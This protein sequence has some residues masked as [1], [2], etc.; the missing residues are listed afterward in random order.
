MK[1]TFAKRL[2]SLFLGCL[3][4]VTPIT[5]TKINNY[6]IVSEAATGRAMV[7]TTSLNVRSDAGTAF[8]ALGKLSIGSYVNVVG[9]KRG[10]DGNTWYQITYSTGQGDVSGYVLSSYIKFP[11]TGAADSNFESYLA[12]Q[13]FPESYKPYL[14]DLHNSHPNWKFTALQTG[15][16]WNTAVKEESVVG[17]NLTGR[18]NISSWKSTAPGAYNWDTSTWPGFDGSA[19]VAA[20]E[21]IIRYYMDPRNFINEKYIFQFMNQKYDPQ[22]QTREALAAMVSGTFLAG[23][24][25]GTASAVQATSQTSQSSQQTTSQLPVSPAGTASSG[26][27]EVQAAPGTGSSSPA[28]PGGDALPVSPVDAAS[29]NDGTIVVSPLGPVASVSTNKV[30]RVMEPGPAGPG[31]SAPVSVADSSSNA[32]TVTGGTTYVDVIMNAAAQSGVNPYILASMIIQEQG[33]Q[34]TGNSISGKFSG[35]QGYYNFFNVEAYQ[36]GSMGAVERGLWWAAQS[37]S[38]GRPW[39]TR[40]KAI[41]GGAMFYGENYLKKGQTTLYLKKFNVQ[42]SNLYKHQYMTNVLAAAAE[43]LT[44]AKITSLGNAALDFVIPVYKNMPDNPDVKPTGDGCPNNKLK[45]IAVEGFGITPSFDKDIN[46]YDLIVDASVTSV[47]VSAGALN[48]TASI[49][50]TGTI[51]LASGIN[52]IVIAVRAQNGDVRN[53]TLNIVRQTGGPVYN[54]SIS[55]FAPAGNS[56]YTNSSSAGNSGDPATG[57]G[58]STNVS[59]S[60]QGNAS[61]PGPVSPVDSVPQ[62]A[63]A[64][65]DNESVAGFGSA[66]EGNIQITVNKPGTVPNDVVSNIVENP[67]TNNKAEAPVTDNKVEA[68]IVNNVIE[69]KV[70]KPAAGNAAGGISVV[71]GDSN[72]DGKLNI[73]DVLC[74]Q[75]HILGLASID[76]KYS[77]LADVNGNGK[78]DIMDVLLMQKDILGI[79]KLN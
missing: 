35:Y 10:T 42:G 43:G 30:N 21:D 62:Q 56:G 12:S 47:K 26:N 75:R 59:I 38:Y 73:M 32:I 27:S 3:M 1:K 61:Q 5:G 76:N 44:L 53:Y 41:L 71:R 7:N 2:A 14:R 77:S 13:G 6:V 74:V 64:A 67:V 19:W 39:N 36:S 9:E 4:A 37:G 20:S 25:P 11:Q 60:G 70:E 33:S 48:N 72:G 65:A 50:G 28:A 58:A 78:I 46:T 52:A 79:A 23:T 31:N 69:Q 8:P 17:R 18:E 29:V 45:S 40:E 54:S 66:P 24:I 34:G 57:P 51:D 15:L 16:D 22:A 68:P 55:G 63:P 49:A